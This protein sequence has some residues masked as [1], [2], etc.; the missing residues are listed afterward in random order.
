MNCQGISQYWMPW[1]VWSWCGLKVYKC[2]TDLPCTMHISHRHSPN[3][4]NVLLLAGIN[5][6]R[7][8]CLVCW[9]IPSCEIGYPTSKSSVKFHCHMY[10]FFLEMHWSTIHF[11]IALVCVEQCQLSKCI[12]MVHHFDAIFKSQ[13]ALNLIPWLVGQS[14]LPLLQ[15]HLPLSALGHLSLELSILNIHISVSVPPLSTLSCLLF[16]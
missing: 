9:S 4:S 10:E 12:F 13:N 3:T 6:H 2:L 15:E 11:H 7:C 1:K 5:I 16:F 8:C 14:L